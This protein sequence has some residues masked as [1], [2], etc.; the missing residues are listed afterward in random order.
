MRGWHM[1]R[2]LVPP[3]AAVAAV[4][5][6][7]LGLL[8]MHGVSATHGMAMSSAGMGAPMS[9]EQ[10]APEAVEEAGPESSV[11][12]APCPGAGSFSMCV[13]APPLAA[14]GA[15]PPPSTLCDPQCTLGEAY[16]LD[17]EG[18]PPTPPSLDELSISRT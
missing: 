7:M 13:P 3:V 5:L 6:L 15:V 2:A 9:A 1:R 14:A 4:F 18:P 16:A 11:A 10:A 12:P 8:G 17:Y